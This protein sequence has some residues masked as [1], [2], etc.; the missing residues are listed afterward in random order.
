LD[1][2]LSTPRVK[3]IKDP[4][5]WWHENQHV[6]PRLFRMA[7]DYL[8]VPGLSCYSYTCDIHYANNYLATSVAVERIFSRGRLLLSYIRNRLS[9]ESTR[10]LLCL[11][12]WSHMGFMDDEDLKAAAELEDVDI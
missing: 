9:G 2:Y 10:A 4:L 1:R 11:G 6:Y 3:K 8:N 7:R 12:A 5:K